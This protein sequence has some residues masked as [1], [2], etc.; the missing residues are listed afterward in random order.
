MVRW[1]RKYAEKANQNEAV[2]KLLPLS[3][4][5]THAHNTHKMQCRFGKEKPAQ[6]GNDCYFFSGILLSQTL[7]KPFAM[8][9]LIRSMSGRHRYNREHEIQTSCPRSQHWA[10]PGCVA[11]WQEVFNPQPYS[12]ARSLLLEIQ[13][14]FPNISACVICPS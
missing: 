5:R 1:S 7:L 12:L 11:H 4:A 9:K 6:L 13:A 2:G 3:P 8:V 10:S 14:C